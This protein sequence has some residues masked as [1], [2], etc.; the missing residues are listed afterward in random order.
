LVYR[1]DRQPGKDEALIWA[2][3]HLVIFLKRV[4][5]PYR[6]G[7]DQRQLL[8]VIDE[9]QAFFPHQR[10]K[11]ANAFRWAIEEGRS[12]GLRLWTATQ[13]PT[14]IP[15][16]FRD[17]LEYLY[18]LALGMGG[19]IEAIREFVGR[20]E[21]KRLKGL[22]KHEVICYRKDDQTVLEGTSKDRW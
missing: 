19:G 18:V 4:Q 8:L 21:I 16:D 20:E 2:L 6:D 1:L 15:P 17:N 11:G 10:P 13:R 22:K 14:R 5:G 9:V 3:H 7:A 12:W